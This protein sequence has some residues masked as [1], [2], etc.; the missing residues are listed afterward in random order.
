MSKIVTSFFILVVLV[1]SSP[2]FGA[3]HEI[4]QAS[5]RADGG[6]PFK[7]TKSG[8][9]KLTSNLTVPAGTDG[10]DILAPDVTLDLNGFS[11]IGPVVCAVNFEPATCPAP[12]AGVG[13]RAGGDEGPS[14]PGDVKVLNGSVRGMG[15]TG[16]FMTGDGSLVQK[17][18]AE[19]NAGTGMV[20]AGSV[21]DSSAIGNGSTGIFASIVRD[22]EAASNA[23]DGIVL[24]ARG[25]V[26]IGDLSSINGGR[27]IVAPNASVTGSTMT[28]NK[29][30]GLFAV[31]PSAILNNTIVANASSIQTEDAGCVLENNGTRP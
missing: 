9:Y 4:D 17:V 29:G 13:I 15:S 6:F 2:V 23:K 24:D 18:S 20:V 7:I 31:C 30:V 1:T 3:K 11:I 14:G 16:I 12:T 10:V 25:G 27:G 5:V 28:L 21:V 19:S 26:A 22:S 8:S